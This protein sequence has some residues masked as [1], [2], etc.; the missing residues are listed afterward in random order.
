M[1]F[2]KVERETIINFNEEEDTASI[3]TCNKRWMRQLERYGFKITHE[4]ADKGGI[5]AKEFEVPKEL[6]RIPRPP[7]GK[8]LAQ[9]RTQAETLRK[10]RFSRK[11]PAGPSAKVEG[12]D[13]N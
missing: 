11:I 5:H 2:S 13:H 9:R 6:I 3:Y 1:R 4:Y 8:E 12:F 7:T 10:Y